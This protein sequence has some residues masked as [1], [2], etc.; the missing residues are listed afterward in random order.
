LASKIPFF[1]SKIYLGV[2][3]KSMKKYRYLVI[4]P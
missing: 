2:P 4:T 1:L 3:K